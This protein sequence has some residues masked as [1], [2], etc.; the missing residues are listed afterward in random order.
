M[1]ELINPVRTALFWPKCDCPTE[2]VKVKRDKSNGRHRFKLLCTRCGRWG[3]KP[4]PR[5]LVKP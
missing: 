5:N 3:T 4:V 2:H 1:P